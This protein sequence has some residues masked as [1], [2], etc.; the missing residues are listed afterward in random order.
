MCSLAS[1]AQKRK[2]KE[3]RKN[4][5]VE[6]PAPIVGETVLKK[7]A[8]MA[9]EVEVH[10]ISVQQ[11]ICGSGD[12]IR[13]IND[14]GTGIGQGE[15]DPEPEGGADSRRYNSWDDEEEDF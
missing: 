10:T 14:G 11:M 4:V 6:R 2:V 1:C 7:K 3:V 15:G 12:P 5:S 8:Y 13:N 9:P